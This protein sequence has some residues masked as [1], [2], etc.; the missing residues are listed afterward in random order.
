MKSTGCKIGG[1]FCL[2]CQDSIG[3]MNDRENTITFIS[4]F[5]VCLLVVFLQAF[6]KQ[7]HREMLDRS[8]RKKLAVLSE[9]HTKQGEKYGSYFCMFTFSVGDKN[10]ECK[11]TGNYTKLKIGDTVLI[12]Y[13]AEN[14]SVAR[15]ID[16]YYMKKH[17]HLR[18]SKKSGR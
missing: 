1:F 4:L 8:G 10:Y 13:A 17:H 3:T 6:L 14:P 18:K 5:I 11:Q 12:E 16:K 9:I 2:E 7:K 15:V